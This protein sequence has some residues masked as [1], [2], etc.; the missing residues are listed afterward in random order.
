MRSSPGQEGPEYVPLIAKKQLSS[1]RIVANESLIIQIQLL[2]LNSFPV[3]DVVVE[4]EK[5]IS[6]IFL[7]IGL[8]DSTIPVGEIAGKENKTLFYILR[9]NVET[10]INLT[11]RATTVKYFLEPSTVSTSRNMHQSFSTDLEIS[12]LSAADPTVERR[13]TVFMALI[14]LTIY[15]LLMIMRAILSLARPKRLKTAEAP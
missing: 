3:Y 8:D 9:V 10:P 15:S 4:E 6:P 12:V 1:N 5:F 2:N 14:L 13:E 7:Y 11:L